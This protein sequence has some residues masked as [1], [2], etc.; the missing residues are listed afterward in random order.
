MSSNLRFYN[1]TV[2]LIA[3]LL[4]ILFVYTGMNKLIDHEQFRVQLGESPFLA[5]FGDIIS[6]MLPIGEILLALALIIKRTRLLGLFLSF[7]LMALFTGYI[8]LMLTYAYDLPCSCGGI[9]VE[10]SWNTHLIFNAIFTILAA[11]GVI[12]ESKLRSSRLPQKN[13]IASI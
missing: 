1:I 8:W 3:A 9:M 6:Y 12:L 2:Q 4:L 13:I 5:N 10:M 7:F 11:I